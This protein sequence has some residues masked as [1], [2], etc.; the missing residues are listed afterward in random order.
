[1]VKNKIKKNIT[2]INTISSVILQFVTLLNG[3][4][5]PKL[6]LSY[7]GSEVNGLVS[8]ITQFLGYIYLVEGGI[9]GVLMSNLYGPLANHDNKK[10]SSIV[11]TSD[12][13]YKK[14]SII[15]TIYTIIL[16]IIYPIF[17]N[18]SFSYIY[19][20]SIIII[21]SINLLIQYTFSITYR[22]LLNADKKVYI[23][24]ITQSIILVLNMI[25]C[26]ISLKIYPSIHVLK[27]VSG[28][29]YI[30]Q[31]LVFTFYINKYY[32]IDKDV[33]IDDSFSKSRWAGFA[34]NVASFIH[35]NT[36]I[37]IL[38]LFLN[39]KSVSVYAV[40]NLV[41]SG[42]RQI[43]NAISSAIYPTIGHSY[44]KDSSKTLNNKFN[45]YETIIFYITYSV[46]TVAFFVITPFVEL[47]TSNIKDISYSMPALGAL[48]IIAEMVYLLRTPHLNIAYSA[49]KFKEMT[50]PS[51]IEAIIN[52]VISVIL[53]SKFGLVGV[54]IGTLIA[55]IYRTI[56]QIILLKKDVLYRD[57]SVFFKKL[58]FYSIGFCMIILVEK[59]I[60][61]INITNIYSWIMYSFIYTILSFCIYT[62]I[63]LIIYKKERR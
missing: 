59:Y 36:D 19:I 33:E 25:L 12:I 32:K 53:V 49:K 30:V 14:L 17:V 37:V 35:F 46:F 63:S 26:Y 1:M 31:P 48:M 52:I 61:N 20:F 10:I 58:V 8:S 51:V 40:Y 5:V 57:I 9:T 38:N 15:F 7:F 22:T 54:A 62:L 39:L 50:L 44:V 43:I 27:L 13:F 47:Y 34:I 2:I 45:L 11:K 16:A 56:S 55:M 4:I 42:L 41:V 24:S 28:I 3:F 60:I 21:L 6:I 29:L 18:T 23:V